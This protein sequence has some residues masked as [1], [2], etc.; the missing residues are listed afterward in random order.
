[1]FTRVTPPV[2]LCKVGSKNPRFPHFLTTPIGRLDMFVHPP[3]Y[4]TARSQTTDPVPRC[5]KG[6]YTR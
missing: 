4:A 1:M 3:H 2:A 6:R 5:S